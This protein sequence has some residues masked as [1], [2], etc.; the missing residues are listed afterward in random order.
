MTVRVLLISCLL[1]GSGAVSAAA[2]PVT[3]PDDQAEYDSTCNHYSNRARFRARNDAPDFIAILADACLAAQ[4]SLETGP[5]EERKAARAFLDRLVAFRGTIKDMNVASFRRMREDPA[6]YSRGVSTE[7]GVTE[8]GEMLIAK[9]FGLTAA[10][11]AWLDTG[12]EFDMA[13][14]PGTRG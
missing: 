4:H 8:A 6:S 11:D 9:S 7:W 1:A 5:P 14:S 12:P 10:F 3:P 2:D 13:L